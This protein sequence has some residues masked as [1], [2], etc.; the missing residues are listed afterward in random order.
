VVSCH[1]VSTQEPCVHLSFSHTCRMSRPSHSSRFDDP[2]NIW[3]GIQ[4]M[5]LLCV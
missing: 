4:I 1:G 3:W 2:S 5:K